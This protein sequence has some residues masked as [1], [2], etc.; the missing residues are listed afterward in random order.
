V[1]SE[2][3]LISSG[4]A[5]ALLAP[6]QDLP[7][8]KAIDTTDPDD[9]PDK[10]MIN[11]ED[12][13]LYR[14]DRDS[15]VSEDSPR[16]IA[17]TTGVG[18][19][20]RLNAQINDHNKLGEI[21]GGTTGEYYHLSSSDYTT[22]TGWVGGTIPSSNLPATV[23]YTDQANTFTATQ[24]ITGG[25]RV[26]TNTL[27]VDDSENA[28][29]INRSIDHTN[30]PNVDLFISGELLINGK[31]IWLGGETNDY[32]HHDPVSETFSVVIQDNS[33]ISVTE[34]R[35]STI[36]FDTEIIGYDC[37]LTPNHGGTRHTSNQLYFSTSSNKWILEGDIY[38]G[39]DLQVNDSLS[40]ADLR[41]SERI[42]EAGITTTTTSSIFDF[43]VSQ[44]S[45]VVSTR[46]SGTVAISGFSGGVNGQ[47]VKLIK[48][49]SATGFSF[50]HNH[51]SA[52]E[53]IYT[54]TGASF[55]TSYDYGVYAFTFHEGV[56][57]MH[58]I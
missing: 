32:L 22:L 34:T 21:Q 46:S 6:V 12:S 53:P 17:P 25:L 28:V 30:F 35:F 29:A 31:K 49:N 55:S 41:A 42:V 38:I 54:P 10:I 33:K 36:G 18:M 5:S 7:A 11:V 40:C 48:E 44:T 13:G 2:L 23:A 45:I 58:T 16:I 20:Y 14:L 1:Q 15:T 3:D 9:Y 47:T 51:S 57:Y 39:D 27:I 19:W 52:R 50:S 8:L 26:N 56:W 24:E 43:D 37:I 4:V